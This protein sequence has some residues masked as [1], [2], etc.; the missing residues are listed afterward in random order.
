[1]DLAK[2]ANGVTEILKGLGV[3]PNDPN[4]KETPY[5]V[6]YYYAEIADGLLNLDSRIECLFDA[7]FPTTYTGIIHCSGIE[8]YSLC[9]HHLL[10]VRY[11]IDIGYIPGESTKMVIGASKLSRLADLLAKRPVLQED[12]TDNI[13]DSLIKNIDPLGVAVVVRGEHLCMKM[14]GIKQ[15]ESKFHT[16]V[17]YGSFKDN[18]ETREEFFH[19]MSHDN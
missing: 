6:A 19:L 10:P 16:S 9:P 7:K 17:M 5:R 13:A 8:V 12:L 3:D 15:S 14:R 11:K 4:F 2:I 1:M 18:P